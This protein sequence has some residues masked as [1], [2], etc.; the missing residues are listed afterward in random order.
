MF[1]KLYHC[2][3][4]SRSFESRRVFLH[5]SR[6]SFHSKL[7]VGEEEE[8][9]ESITILGDKRTSMH[10]ENDENFDLDKLE[11]QLI[12]NDDT[13]SETTSSYNGESFSKADKKLILLIDEFDSADDKDDESDDL[14]ELVENDPERIN[15]GPTSDYYKYQQRL[16]A[17]IYGK[18]AINAVDLTDFKRLLEENN[19]LSVS[20]NSD[21]IKIYTL[22]K[23]CNMSR[24]NAEKLLRLISD[25]RHSDGQQPFLCWRTFE[26]AVQRETDMYTTKE[27]VI[28]WP[29]YFRMNEW[30]HPNTSCPE[31]IVIRLRDPLELIADQ[32]VSPFLHFLWKDHINMHCYEKFNEKGE[33]VYCDI[34]SSD[35]AKAAQ[36]EIHLLDPNGILLPIILYSDGVALGQHMDTYLCPVMGTLGWYS[37]KLFQKDLSKFVIGYIDKINNISDA[38]LIHHLVTVC[39]MSATKAK[40]NIVLFKKNVFLEF[41]KLCIET[42]QLS[43]SRGMEMKILG[44]EGTKIFYPRIAFHIGDDPA[45]H[46]VASIKCGSMV[47][48]PCIKC[49]Y[50]LRASETYV[51]NIKNFRNLN[52][53][54]LNEIR[55]AESINLK[56][57][58]K[59][60]REPGENE[61]LDTLEKKGYLPINNP[62]FDAPF[63][64]DN[65]IYNSPPD[66]MHLFSAG[67][68]K[69][70]LLWTLIIID[71]ISKYDGEDYNFSQSTGLFDI[72]LKQFPIIPKNIPHLHMCRFEKG[73]MYIIDNKSV[74]D[75]TNA[76]GSGGNFRSS[77]NVVALFQTRFAVSFD[78]LI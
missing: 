44:H 22:A 70:V 31:N 37:K 23:D 73:L 18:L 35:W 57:L 10:M 20:R 47:R 24:D 69:S 74:K 26:R 50:D 48:H 17:K 62:F 67:L 21:M 14:G 30:N 15:E 78:I 61:L 60:H 71:A 8:E 65:S 41:W 11:A 63:G 2:E 42:I 68:I 33:K 27:K 4:C 19:L 56:V 54:L 1:S 64:P 58:K 66:L 36:A 16:M 51:F 55:M 5:H 28:P 25:S 72:R 49:M 13:F 75:K 39:K 7:R 43:A 9:K 6:T 38:V 76:T 32:C 34:M 77:E 12:N 40:E 52:H 59:E 53:D 3:D 45:Q 46:E 29:E